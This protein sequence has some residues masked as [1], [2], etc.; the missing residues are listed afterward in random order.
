MRRKRPTLASVSPLTRSLVTNWTLVALAVVSLA[1]VVVT[2]ELPTSSEIE[3]RKQHLLERFVEDDVQR[4]ELS[5]GVT[6]VRGDA[7][8]RFRLTAPTE[9]IA[10]DAAV[11]RLLRAVRFATWLRRVAPEDVDEKAMGLSTPELTLKFSLGSG[12]AEIAI[13]G[14]APSPP[15]ARYVAV[16]DARG[17]DTYVVSEGTAKDL[18]PKAADFRVQ[19]LLPVRNQDIRRL[20]VIASNRTVTLVNDDG[21]RFEHAF[22]GA[23]LDPTLIDR[24]FLQL[25]RTGSDDFLDTSE[26]LA[27]Q[28]A[29]KETIT[30]RYSPAGAKPPGEIVLGGECPKQKA[31]LVAVRTKPEPIA[32]CVQSDIEGAFVDRPELLLDPKLFRTRADEVEE[33]RVD[34]GDAHLEYARSGDGFHMRTPKSG[35]I[36]RQVGEARLGLLVD[37]RGEWLDPATTKA[38]FVARATASVMKATI[39]DR[40][41][42]SEVVELGSVGEL[43]LV[44]RRLDDGALLRI[45]EAT[46]RAF[47]VDALMLKSRALLDVPADQ[48]TAIEIA[49]AG[50]RQKVVREGPGKFRLEQPA[51]FDIDDGLA[52]DL[53]D[54]LRQLSASEWVSESTE[55]HFGFDDPLVCTITLEHADAPKVLEIGAPAPGGVFATLDRDGTF[56]LPQSVRD[57]LTTWVVDRSVFMLD[58]DTLEQLELATA[59]RHLV[60]ERLGTSFVQRSGNAATSPGR[61]VELLDAFSLLRTEGLVTTEPPSVA[62]GARSP[63]LSVIATLRVDGQRQRRRFTIGTAD[64]F[65]DVAAYYAW[66]SDG[67]GVYALARESVRRILEL[68]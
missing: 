24:L 37:A 30:L 67:L 48:F 4:V 7:D 41:R 33:V 63:T 22:G 55:G 35:K 40:A 49:W 2:R 44:A 51:G 39:A 66:P 27:A 3:A 23:R 14:P 45:D 36:E 52:T 59:D 13:G 56:V 62:Q 65:G 38:P 64:T 9:A 20:E 61:I 42:A 31:L 47:T 5:S 12:Q 6:I 19:R 29:A 32:A 54:A 58:T 8:E 43:G 26:A 46:A 50:N 10:D 25:A 11:D 28:K 16:S 34:Q 53:V 15:K 17:N 1:L 68:W 18:S 57:A 60:L 21:F